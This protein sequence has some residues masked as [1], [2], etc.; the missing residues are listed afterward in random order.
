MMRETI[1][2]SFKKDGQ[3]PLGP[4]ALLGH[5]RLVTNGAAERYENN[6]PVFANGVTMIHNGIVVN[7]GDL[8]AAH[9][10]LT[11]TAEVDTEVMAALAGKQIEQ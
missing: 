1:R 8:W 11:R 10:E 2:P 5:T 4:I 7:V 3:G 9:G 6:Q